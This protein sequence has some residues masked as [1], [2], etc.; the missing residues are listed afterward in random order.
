MMIRLNRQ[1]RLTFARAKKRNTVERE[2][3]LMQLRRLFPLILLALVLAACEGL[4]GEPRVVATLPPQVSSDTTSE[5]DNTADV[6]ALGGEVWASN[7]AECHGQ[8][9]EGTAEG[10][11]LPDLSGYSDEQIRAS[12][13]SGKGDT[14]PAFGDRLLTDELTAAITYARM[15][16]LAHRRSAEANPDSQQAAAADSTVTAPV[17]AAVPGVVTGQVSNGTTA[18]SVPAALSLTLHV[19]KSEFSEESFTVTANADG[20]YRFENVPFNSAYQYVITVPYAGVQFVSEIAAVEPAQPELSLPITVY[21]GGTDESALQI[22]AISSQAMVRDHSLQIIQIISF[23]NTSDR[24]YFNADE[25]S[26]TSVSVRLPL[27]A[28]LLNSVSDSYIIS[29]DETLIT[30]T[31]PV[32]PGR[33][34][35]MHLAYSL[36]Y[37]Q[38]ATIDQVFDYPLNGE[39]EVAVTTEG[40]VLTGEGFAELGPVAFGE[41]QMMSYGG[42]MTREA[43]TSLRYDISG[44]PV[45]VAPQQTTNPVLTSP[46]AYILIGAGLISLILALIITLRERLS[47]RKSSGKASMSDLMEQIAALDTRHQSGKVNRRVYERQ[48]A[49]LKARLSALMKPE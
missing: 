3:I 13:T 8:T 10:A 36:P 49:A 7:C 44:V 2:A 38:L 1:L 29:S 24:V 41:R 47:A 39:V 35:A 40:L 19:V 42:V 43:G 16:S 21:E 12:I 11:P 37:G 23:V 4:A 45:T 25:D 46:I 34:Q 48:R 33:S 30:S 14:M 5:Q 15:M 28:T 20:T 22:T 17:E 27:N 6:M 26:G 31:R 9:G 32:L 18:A